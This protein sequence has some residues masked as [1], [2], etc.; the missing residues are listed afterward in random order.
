MRGSG[1]DIGID[2]NEHSPTGPRHRFGGSLDV[3]V[4]GATVAVSFALGLAWDLDDRVDVQL[5]SMPLLD[6]AIGLAILVLAGVSLLSAVRWRQAHRE[7]A[8][9]EQVESRYRTI[10]ERVPA[11]AYVWDG[12]DAPGEAPA[13]YISPQI[14]P[15]LGY[16]PEEWFQRP[17]LWSERVHDDD[18]PVVLASWDEAVAAGAVFAQEYRIR[19]RDGSWAWIRDEANP[20]GPGTRGAPMFQ[21]VMIDVTDRK[22]AEDL[23]RLLVEQL[24][25]ATYTDAV[26]EVSTALFISPQYEQLTG[27]TAAE[28]LRDPSLWSR[29]LHPDDRARVLAE[30]HRTNETGDPFDIDYRIVR[31]DGGITWLHDHAV[32][33]RD[34]DGRP[35]W[36]GVLTDVTDRR[37]AEEALAGHD[38]ILQA[39][40]YAAERFLRAPTWLEPLDEVLAH[41]GAAGRGTRASVWRNGET[42]AG[43]TDTTLL[44]AWHAPD[45]TWTYDDPDLVVRFPMRTGGFGRW[46]DALSAGA[47]VHGRVR[48][49]PA[50]ERAL[51]EG[52]PFSIQAVLCLPI[53]VDGAWWGYLSLDRCA[54]DDLWDDAQ[55]EALSVAANTLGAAIARQ[56]AEERLSEAQERYRLLV[57]KTPVITYVDEYRPEHGRTWPTTYISPQIET[58]LGFGPDA[59]RGDPSLWD[60][61]IHPDDYE[62]AAQAD[63]RHYATGEPLDVELRIRTSDGGWRWM[64]DQAVIIR[65]EDGRPRWS[66]GI[67]Y[68][69]TERKLA[70]L[71]LDTAERRYRSLIETIPAVT[72]V[73]AVDEDGTT[74]YV[75]P[76][77]EAIF[78]Y[79]QQEWCDDI[80]LWRRGVHPDDL[81][82]V[83]EATRAHHEQGSPLE[84]DYRFRHR[85]GRWRWVRDQAVVL[86]DDEG[87]PSFSQGVMYDITEQ[88]IAEEQVRDAEE[89]FR[90][91]VEHVPAAIYV[92]RADD[93]LRTVYA[94]PQIEA[95]TGISPEVWIEDPDAWAGSIDERDR[96]E[97]VRSYRAAIA[98]QLPWSAEYR[99]NTRDGRTIWVH[100]ETVFLHDRSGAPSFIQGVLYD[101][102]ERK[103]AEQALRA[104]ERREREAAERL[105]ALDEMKNT[106][107]AAVSHELRSPLTSILGLSLTLERDPAIDVRDR[108]DL[109]QRLATNARKLDQLL[110]D[111]LDIDRLS[112]G[113]VEPA[114]RTI[115]VGGLARRA[116][117][118]LDILAD[119][120]VTVRADAVEVSVDPAKVERIVENLLVNAARHTDQDRRIW[121]EVRAHEMG[122]L[123][124]VDDDGPGVP[125]P[126]RR[127]IFEPF[128][129]GPSASSHAPGTGI[130]LS[131]VARFAELHGGR[132]WVQERPGGGASFRVF[133]PGHPDPGGDSGTEVKGPPR[134]ERHPVP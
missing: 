130:G 66:Q 59:W 116:A 102:T 78:G 71:A 21:G 93:S 16:T 69:I 55:V 64:R 117:R 42:D 97:V 17:E 62:R 105:R 134:A 50:C 29:M 20:V 26:D 91:I 5:Q 40:A 98:Q 114:Y 126:I 7:R 14:E 100:D 83:T 19:R 122:V 77:V 127:A 109:L 125:E 28:R 57:E 85:D 68:D 72:Y 120:D 132:A 108:D 46:A 44:R 104:S 41:L 35:I 34:R 33:G 73:D 84:V 45:W 82:A 87:L 52:E 11:V 30:S 32:R 25:I 6:E 13:S 115:D 118:H 51:L 63:L 112:R 103:L 67:L 107:L 54:D 61:L 9:R 37:A 49:F 95:I 4:I 101:I 22:E 65:D 111:L 129:Q 123:I 96:E 60:D 79:T 2:V 23:Y 128:H 12:A 99:V 89:R 70:E 58:I 113:I 92:D 27:Y 88:K 56:E 86:L 75:S 121:L 74:A 106:F 131:L 76:Q 15:L 10:V 110:K 39:T 43:D 48:D 1:D 94:S 3:V 81:E 18:L 47:P 124:V 36:Q 80:D 8:L 38:R 119:R 133:L 90:G 24:P 53:V 31:A